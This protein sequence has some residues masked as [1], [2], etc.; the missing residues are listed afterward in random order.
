MKRRL[1]ADPRY[2]CWRTTGSLS[3]PQRDLDPRLEEKQSWRRWGAEGEGPGGHHGSHTSAFCCRALLPAREGPRGHW[4]SREW[5]FLANCQDECQGP[6]PNPYELKRGEGLRIQQERLLDRRRQAEIPKSKGQKE[7]TAL[8]RGRLWLSLLWEALG[9]HGRGRGQQIGPGQICRE[10]W[11]A[12]RSGSASQHPGSPQPKAEVSLATRTLLLL[13]CRGPKEAE[14]RDRL[15]APWGSWNGSACKGLGK[16]GWVRG[17][18]EGQRPSDPEQVALQR[19][20]SQGTIPDTIL[21]GRVCPSILMGQ[22][23]KM[24]LAWSWFLPP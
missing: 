16:V 15:P 22:R 21:L 14:I 20:L 8:V 18:E 12:R 3:R 17:W 11:L 7:G 13:G 2:A 9:T 19:P 5:K 4:E 6:K 23:Q 10:L 24:D 1:L